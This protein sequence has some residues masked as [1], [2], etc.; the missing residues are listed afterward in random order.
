MG[1]LESFGYGCLVFSRN[2]NGFSIE[3]DPWIDIKDSTNSSPPPL[4]PRLFILHSITSL[5]FY[6]LTSD[7]YYAAPIGGCHIATLLDPE[8]ANKRKLLQANR[9]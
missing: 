4:P 1:A 6:R 7:R 2:P 5:V 8:L 3:A 9:F